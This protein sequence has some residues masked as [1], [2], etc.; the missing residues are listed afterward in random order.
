M[1]CLC[2]LV[3]LN[4]H[5]MV[6]VLNAL[7]ELEVGNGFEVAGRCNVGKTLV[8]LGNFLLGILL[9]GLLSTWKICI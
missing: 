9:L 3:F 4:H 2:P 6:V 1:G 8:N 5:F 7:S